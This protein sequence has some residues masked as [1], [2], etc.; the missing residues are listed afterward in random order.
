[1]ISFSTPTYNKALFNRNDLLVPGSILLLSFL[2]VWLFASGLTREA[3][4][5]LQ[6][7][8]FIRFNYFL[9]AT[10]GINPYVW[11]N[12]T[13]FGNALVGLLVLSPLIYY[14][15]KVWA[16]IF[17]SIPLAIIFSGVGKALAAMPRPAVALDQ[18]RFII[19]DGP[20]IGYTSLPSGHTITVFCLVTAAV[21]SFRRYV[22]YRTLF[23]SAFGFA[24][25]LVISRIAVGA[26]WPMDIVVG[27][28]L[29]YLA[30]LSGVILVH[31]FR[32]WWGWIE[33]P[34]YAVAFVPVLLLFIV[35]LLREEFLIYGFS[36][37]N[38]LI[39]VATVTG[40]LTIVLLFK[41]LRK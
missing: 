3:Y 7:D 2:F 26:H 29:G 16:A 32:A 33:T 39:W 36:G 25:V 40:M 27:A 12:L 1:M 8:F 6:T 37:F 15:P 34:K 14:Y 4:V 13:Y 35:A 30:G 23:Y 20:L 10:L 5:A 24:L 17:G 31:T 18:S 19:I 38:A 28:A 41:A 11:S 9:N 22:F 21:L